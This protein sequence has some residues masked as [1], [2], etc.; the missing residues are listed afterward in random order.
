MKAKLTLLAALGVFTFA[1]TDDSTP[2]F[3]DELVV[4]AY[5][6]EGATLSLK[7][8]HQVPLDTS[9]TVGT[10]DIDGLAIT[11]SDDQTSYQ[12]QSA[13]EGIYFSSDL[14]V[15]SGTT[16]N[17]SFQYKDQVVTGSTTVPSSPRDVTQSATSINVPS[18]GNFTPGSGS[19]FTF[20][21][22][23]E[24]SWTNDDASYYLVVVENID[25]NP[26]AIN[27]FGG[28]EPPSRVFRNEPIQSDAYQINSQ[29]FQYTGRHNI[30]IFHLNPEYAALYEN[31]STSSQNLNAPQTNLINAKG[32]F[33]ATSPDTLQITVTS[34]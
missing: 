23:V 13:G 15:K 17:V 32:V 6:T 25:D 5:L 20:P 26:T 9:I 22:P 21:D 27:D 18:F 16:Y 30:I 7:V 24:I 31:N 33:T 14:L 34:N 19:G 4:E 3:K 2:S 8:S 28:E 1:C 11:I 10:D 29:Q 12:L